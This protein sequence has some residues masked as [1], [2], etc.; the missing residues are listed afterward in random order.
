VHISW[1]LHSVNVFSSTD[2]HATCSS[3]TPDWEKPAAAMVLPGSSGFADSNWRS[4]E[5][6]SDYKAAT[7]CFDSLVRDA[8]RTC[9]EQEDDYKA[10]MKCFDSLVRDAARI[11]FVWSY[12]A[13]PLTRQCNIYFSFSSFSSTIILESILDSNWPLEAIY[14]YIWL[15]LVIAADDPP[16]TWTKRSW[17]LRG[18]TDIQTLSTGWAQPNSL[19]KAVSNSNI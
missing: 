4:D 13:I 15:C 2:D 11:C 18:A 19:K 8:A 5:Q 1:C 7:K 6:D 9:D 14:I 3:Q 10:T 16:P 17:R 12:D